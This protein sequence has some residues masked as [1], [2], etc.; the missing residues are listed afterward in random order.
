MAHDIVAALFNGVYQGIALA[1]VLWLGLRLFRG[2]NAATRHAVTFVALLAVALLPLL[3]FVASFASKAPSRDTAVHGFSSMSVEPILPIPPASTPP[4]AAIQTHEKNGEWL[5]ELHSEGH[6]SATP[7]PAA[8]FA[9]AEL[10]ALSR[11]PKLAVPLSKASEVQ[12]ALYT[13]P[14]S[15]FTTATLSPPI[16]AT[17]PFSRL[18]SPMN[19]ATKEFCG[20]S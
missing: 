20:R 9:S 18:F 10:D 14:E 15:S 19:C 8:G 4:N 3:H 5:S 12:T 1:V 6:L 7:N 13:S 16:S 2:S 11:Y 17:V